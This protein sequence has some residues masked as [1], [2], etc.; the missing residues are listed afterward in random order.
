[1][2]WLLR[3]PTVESNPTARDERRG[4]WQA[5]GRHG[6]GRKSERRI[7][8]AAQGDV[9]AG[10]LWATSCD[11]KVFFL[12]FN[13]QNTVFFGDFVQFFEQFSHS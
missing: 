11:R 6:P 1:L 9:C 7:S 4:R 8:S 13:F 3:R 10:G 2:T 12:C 5:T